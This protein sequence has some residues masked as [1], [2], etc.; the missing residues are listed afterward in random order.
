MSELNYLVPGMSCD[1]CKLAVTTEVRGVAGVRAV[2]VDLDTKLVRVSGRDL[3][4]AAVVA[5]I[6][7]AGYDAE[8]AAWVAA[9]SAIC[10]LLPVPGESRS[11]APTSSASSVAWNA[12]AP[13][14]RTA[15][16]RLN[17]GPLRTGRAVNPVAD[18]GRTTL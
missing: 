8:P 10:R 9:L 1:H 11:E 14:A 7:E 15:G 6:D 18:A 5:A 13:C 3:D 17:T 16:G 2:D 12:A 4:P